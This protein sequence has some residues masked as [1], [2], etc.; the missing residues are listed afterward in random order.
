MI[1]PSDDRN[2]PMT[3]QLALR[4]AVVGTLALMLFALIFFRLWFLQVLSGNQYVAQAQGNTTNTVP[5]NAP[6]GEILD[7]NGTVLVDS[8]AVPAVQIAPSV[9]PVPISL[10]TVQAH[11]VQ[12]PSQD[13]MI[14]NAL[15]RVLKMS[16][17][18]QR[19]TY[20][21]Y[22]GPVI[23]NPALS[24]IA[25][26]VA[27]SVANSPFANATIKTDVGQ[28]VQ[29]YLAERQTQPQYQGVVTQE[30]YLRQYPYGKL[31]AQVFGYVGQPTAAELKQ[32]TYK[33]QTGSDIVGLSGLEYQYN[34]S[35]KGIDGVQRVKVNAAG[36]FQGYG[37]RT[38]PAAGNNLRLSLHLNLEK[39]GLK[40]LQTA[41]TQNPPANSGA[42]VAMNYNTGAIY[43]MGSLP[44]FYPSDFVPTLSSKEWSKLNS[45][46]ANDPLLNRAIG[47]AL[48]DGSTFKPITATAALESGVWSLNNT[49]TDPGSFCYPGENPSLPGSCL[50]NAGNMVGGTI[51][52]QSAI[53]ISDDVFFYNLG[54]KLQFDP[55]KHPNGG[56]LQRWARAYGLG[57]TT[58]VDL[59]GESP[60]VLPTP[61]YLWQRYI[62]EKQC[63]T[64]TGAYAYTNGQ[65]MVS[66]TRLPG[67]KPSPKHPG[68]CGIA[69]PQW[70]NDSWTVGD[71]VESGVGQGD[72]LL[73]PMQ[74]AVVYA[75]LANG[76]TIV[77]PH[78]GQDVQSP[79]GTILQPI[80]PAPKRKLNIN[81]AYLNAI[82]T[83]LHEAAQSPGGTS[84]DVMT[85][86]PMTVYGKTGTAQVGTQQQILTHT[87]IDYAWYA[88]FVKSATKPIVI[89]VSVERGGFGDVAAA[90][91]ARQM[92][93]QWFF[94]NAGQFHRGSSKDL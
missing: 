43:A 42:F 18:P 17:R 15:A 66:A 94:G 24:P 3:P 10:A 92:L 47:S 93:S 51:N 50:H 78:V 34:Q 69:Q 6:R 85:S 71:N 54:Y 35:L 83:G 21:V 73:T 16:T 70:K 75:A 14:F 48:P 11:P 58:G 76:G 22:P 56:Q 86:F 5:I 2:P 25:C 79:N 33:G 53:R 4:V 37:T 26:L 8:Q 67:Y 91:V 88:C 27:K 36:Q 62:E 81:P 87:E 13:T 29:A 82:L 64:A 61:R 60:G 9:L 90:P 68:G 38:A 30:I 28:D 12:I 40:A 89:V 44:S 77:T 39:V 45:T 41:I 52:L 20:Y 80:N 49:Y 23:Y 1:Q 63:E 32:P 59:P 57:Q 74:L 84:S 72:D 55:N 19:C 65:G 31:A 7:A 46:A